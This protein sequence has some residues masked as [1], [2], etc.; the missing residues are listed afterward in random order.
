M[1]AAAIS[2]SPADVLHDAVELAATVDRLA[3]EITGAH[4][5]EP[6]LVVVLNGSLLFAADLVRAVRRHGGGGAVVDFLAISA[7][8]PGQLRV[9][10]EKDL[11]LDI[12]GRA[13]VLVEDIVDTGLTVAYLR[14]ALERRD[15]ASVAVCTL[16]DKAARRILPVPLE[17]V[18]LAAPDRFL[19]GYGLDYRGRYRNL[20]FVAAGDHDHLRADADRYVAQLYAPGAGVRAR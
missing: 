20:S 4:G 3:A 2:G 13:V 6:V 18:G 17:H 15:P 7:Y 11:D 8:T 19:L 9:R 5:P 10:L 1:T 14:E 12:A 16:F